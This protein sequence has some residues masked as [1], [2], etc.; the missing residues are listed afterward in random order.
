MTDSKKISYI[1][2]SRNDSYCGDSVG[3]LQTVVNHTGDI[4][5]KHNKLKESEIVLCDW[6][7]PEENGPLSKRLKLKEATK[8]ILKIVEVPKE[9]GSKY[10][11]D[12]P[13]SEVH[14]M[15]VGF[16]HS[17]GKFFARIDQD[18]LIGERFVDWFYNKFHETPYIEW[19]LVAFS[20]RRNLSPEQSKDYKDW[21]F[22]YDKS[23]SV[24][25]CH[26]NAY[27]SR[28]IPH[29][30]KMFSFYG[31]AVGVMIVERE[32]YLK[33][34]GFNESLI[35][36]NNM[37]TE[38]LNRLAKDTKFVNLGLRTEADFYHLHHP[39][40]EGAANDLS[41][42]HLDTDGSRKTNSNEIRKGIENTNPEDWGLNSEQLSVNTFNDKS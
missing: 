32:L 12:S 1:I 41:Q 13:F 42:P 20:G 14:A 19:P 28:V 3:R 30:K 39:R 11:K 2:A 29:R 25:F 34:M 22:D 10:Q 23:M 35:Y 21:V 9:I 8:S 40:G 7:S 27:Y 36:M 15:N 4:L 16:R 38:F 17:S 18:T 33:H 37:D 31:A 26:P 6:C 5:K 24:E